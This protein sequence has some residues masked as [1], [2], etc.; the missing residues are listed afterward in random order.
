MNG[1]PKIPRLH[2]EY[3]QTRPKDLH[4][5]APWE[6]RAGGVRAVAIPLPTTT[7]PQEKGLGEHGTPH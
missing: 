1:H 4:G 2:L 6:A 3:F 5:L 7:F